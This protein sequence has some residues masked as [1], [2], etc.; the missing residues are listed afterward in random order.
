MSLSRSNPHG[1]CV[2]IDIY[3]N[4]FSGNY[5]AGEKCGHGIM[6]YANGDTYDGN[7][8]ANFPEGQGTKVYGSTGNKYEGGWKKGRRHG[9]GTMHF[10]VAD[11]ELQ[12]CKICFEAEMDALFY[13]CGHVVACEEC[14]RQVKDCPVCRR[15]VDGVV[16]I[17]RTT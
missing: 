11:E 7:W 5:T 12:L 4:A 13:R 1:H 8:E 17:W 14:A 3:G 16:K 2:S 9:Q 15:N 10:E 6:K